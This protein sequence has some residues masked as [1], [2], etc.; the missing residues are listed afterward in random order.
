MYL[1]HVY[2]ILTTQYLYSMIILF[3]NFYRNK[4]SKKYS[5]KYI[6]WFLAYK[7]EFIIFLY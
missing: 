1:F 3:F 7:T 5:K 2:K 4:Y 6:I